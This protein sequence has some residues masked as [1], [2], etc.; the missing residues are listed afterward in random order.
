MSNEIFLLAEHVSNINDPE[1]F[2]QLVCSI[3][4]NR[5]R[6]FAVFRLPACCLLVLVLQTNSMSS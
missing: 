6:E 3:L 4:T 2:P 5:Q 1:I